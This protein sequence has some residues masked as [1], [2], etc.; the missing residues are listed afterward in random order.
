M[1]VRDWISDKWDRYTS[2]KLIETLAGAAS[3]R[4]RAWSMA[5]NYTSWNGLSDLQWNG[6]H[7]S[8]ADPAYVAFL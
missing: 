7:M 4:P 6:R 2:R 8:E 1:G 3:P 5:N